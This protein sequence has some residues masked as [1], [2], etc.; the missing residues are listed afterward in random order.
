MGDADRGLA[1]VVECHATECSDAEDRAAFRASKPV[2]TN[3]FHDVAKDCNA[4]LVS[5]SAGAP[6]TLVIASRMQVEGMIAA[7]A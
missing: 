4:N 7:N 6:K 2:L 5:L 1:I 3:S